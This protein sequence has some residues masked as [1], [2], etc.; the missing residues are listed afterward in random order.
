MQIPNSNVGADFLEDFEGADFAFDLI[1]VE[2]IDEDFQ[3][4]DVA[5]R[6][7]TSLLRQVEI[8]HRT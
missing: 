3:A 1:G 7:L 5:N 4:A 2:E 8:P 6:Q